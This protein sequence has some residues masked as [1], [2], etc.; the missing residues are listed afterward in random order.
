MATSPR[1]GL[2]TE[3]LTT[4]SPHG[5]EI[6]H[7]NIQ[8][9]KKWT[10]AGTAFLQIFD[11]CSVPPPERVGVYCGGSPSLNGP[12]N[13]LQNWRSSLVSADLGP[14]LPITVHV[15]RLVQGDHTM[16]SAQRSLQGQLSQ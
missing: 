15:V 3:E 1:T 13:T 11:R 7:P 14:V 6:I 2:L 16:G 8:V 12:P 9:R 5:D 10:L 4:H